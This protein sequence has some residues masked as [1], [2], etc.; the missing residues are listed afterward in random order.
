MRFALLFVSIALV[1]L[2]VDT[3]KSCDDDYHHHHY[4]DDD[5][6]A[7]LFRSDYADAYH[8]PYDVVTNPFL[9]PYYYNYP[10]S[11]RLPAASGNEK[12]YVEASIIRR[13]L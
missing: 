2:S 7:S 11:L 4:I 12:Q 5:Y 6:P 9:L 10:P 13:L 8:H 3:V 1:C